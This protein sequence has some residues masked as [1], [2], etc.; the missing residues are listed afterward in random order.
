M[1]LGLEALGGL[2]GVAHTGAAELLGPGPPRGTGS[3][4]QH[5]GLVAPGRPGLVAGAGPAGG[6]GGPD[7]RGELAG[8]L[9]AGLGLACEGPGLGGSYPPLAPLQHLSPLGDKFH[10]HAAAV[11]GPHGAHPHPHPHPHAPP[12]AHPGAPPPPP[13]PPPPQRLGAPVS[14]TFTLLQDERG[15]LAPVGPLYAPYRK[16]PLA[17][18]S[19]LH[20]P[21]PPPAPPALG[22]YGPGALAADKLLPGAFEPLLGRAEDALGRGL[23][24]GAGGAGGPGGAGLLGGG[25]AGAGPGAAGSAAAEEINTKEVAQRVTAELKRYSIPQAI[26]AQ[27]VLCRSQG[28]L[29]DLLRNPKP[30]AKLKSGR[31]TFRRMWKWLQEPE[32]QRM[33]ALRLAA[34]KRKEQ[35]Q[36]KE[37]ALQPK[38]Q[39]LVFTD[40]QRRTLVAIFKENRRPSKEMQ[41]TISQQLGLELNTVSNFFM[42]ARRRC[43]NRWAD[44]QGAAPGGPAATFPKA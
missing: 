18:L 38:K 28:T 13:P 41:A 22:A 39:R 9:H 12:H 32:F 21:Q 44:E 23:P 11:S 29:S 43:T 34:C 25:A 36:Q 16:D 17:P 42:N 30:W 31:E 35:E 20:G 26:F 8:A 4:A 37:R 6:A 33:S 24:G 1:E 14:G 19:P 15:A 5:R 2:P 7:F 10:P 40:L 27:R 3:G